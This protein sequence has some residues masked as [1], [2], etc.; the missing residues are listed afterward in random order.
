MMNK[1]KWLFYKGY[2][3]I[4]IEG[5]YPERLTSL[6]E[7]E[8]MALP[9]APRT[10]KILMIDRCTREKNGKLYGVRTVTTEENIGNIK[11]IT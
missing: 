10:A 7:A 2:V 11:E 5:V 4:Q 6:F 3:I 8:R 1:K 9:E